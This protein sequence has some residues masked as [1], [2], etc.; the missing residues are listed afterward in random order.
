M[1][2]LIQEVSTEAA[3]ANEETGIQQIF[4]GLE[5][6]TS[7]SHAEGQRGRTEVYASTGIKVKIYFSYT[8]AK[9]DDSYF[10]K[11]EK[12]KNRAVSY[13]F[14]TP[15]P[16][17]LTSSTSFF[18]FVL[19]PQ[20]TICRL[21]RFIFRTDSRPKRWTWFCLHANESK[22]QPELARAFHRPHPQPLTPP[23][24]LPHPRSS[25][26]SENLS[27]GCLS[28]GLTSDRHPAPPPGR[29]SLSPVVLEALRSAPVCQGSGSRR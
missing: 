26:A 22:V 29:P 9:N 16:Q 6:V 24:T 5:R 8:W 4:G 21:S 7:L 3:R 14:T 15:F 23:T 20:L 12:G 1:S 25:P 19:V 18:F 28:P 10:K 27:P 11:K 17:C 2:R 13:C